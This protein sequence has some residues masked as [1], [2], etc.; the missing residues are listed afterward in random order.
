MAIE[1]FAVDYQSS[2]LIMIDLNNFKSI[3]DTLGHSTGDSLLATLGQRFMTLL[4]TKTCVSRLGGDEFSILTSA[5]LSDDDLEVYLRKLQRLISEP[6]ELSEMSLTIDAAIGVARI[7]DHA[8]TTSEIMVAADVAMYKSKNNQQSYS[9]YDPETDYHTKRNLSISNDVKRAILHDQLF[10]QYQPK[11]DIN[12][13]RVAGLEALIRWQHPELG[14]IRPDEFIPIVENSSLIKPMTMYT[15]ETAVCKQKELHDAGIDITIAV[16]IS[17]K[18][19][20]DNNLA[21][22]I[23]EILDTHGVPPEA[24]TLEIT[25]SAAMSGHEQTLVILNKLIQNNFKLS[26]D[27]FGTSN[28]SF[29]YLKELPAKELKIDKMFITN[30]CREKSDK[31]ISASIIRLAHVLDMKIVAEGIE[32]RESF[33][34]LKT[35]GCDY[36]QGYWISRP[37]P[38]KEIIP[39]IAN[40]NKTAL[41]TPDKSVAG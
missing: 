35:L 11:I 12:T 13:N 25:E 41:L 26:I 15:V 8:V 33:E 17:A 39:W 32:G 16:N 31:V 21:A 3:N 14:L 7:P 24:I 30:I 9:I 4:D 6:I 29:S 37:L 2:V 1:A 36:A 22:D 20:D 34:Y 5:S 40:W 23:T 18:L 27:D 19:L 38:E 10:L 28:A